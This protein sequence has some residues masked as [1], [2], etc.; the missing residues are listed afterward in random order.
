M[1][2]RRSF[3]RRAAAAAAGAAL[4]LLAVQAPRAESPMLDS[5]AEALS[6]RAAD[7]L[8]G[9]ARGVEQLDPMF[10]RAATP[11]V[12]AL[13]ADSRDAA[14]A[15]GVEP[16]PPAIRA[17]LAGYVPAAVLDEV[18]WCADCGGEL[19]LQRAAF[20]LDA[21][22]AITLDHV[23]VFVDRDDALTDPALWVHELRH[24]MQFREWGVSGFAQRYLDDYEAVERDAAD[25]RWEW[26]QRTRWLERR[27]VARARLADE[28]G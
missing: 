12:A 7:G 25:Y 26:V 8:H 3:P 15:D 6:A 17:E 21:T 5:L 1:I 9:L 28:V 16:I 14:L 27:H 18:R 24:V 11:V 2:S 22:P 13:I 4:A 10:V 20:M 23:I 19:S